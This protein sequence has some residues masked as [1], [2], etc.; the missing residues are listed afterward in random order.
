M[1]GYTPTI[2]P[3]LGGEFEFCRRGVI[4]PA[5]SLENDLESIHEL[6]ILLSDGMDG[7]FGG[8]NFIYVSG[9]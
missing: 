7:A 6:G 9:G 2:Q 4:D 8:S 3:S 5:R 1:L